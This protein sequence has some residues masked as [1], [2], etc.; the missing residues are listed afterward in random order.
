MVLKPQQIKL[1]SMLSVRRGAAALEF[2]K[3]AFGAEELFRLEAPDGAIVAQ[4]SIGEREFWISDESPEHLN[5]SPETLGG[6]TVRMI[7]VA[8]DPDALFEHVVE[9]GATIVQSMS[10]EPYGWRIGRIADPFGHHWE[11]GKPIDQ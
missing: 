9:A 7:L 6:G 5:F 8:E 3:R 10:D 4:L 2:Y 11:I 1:A